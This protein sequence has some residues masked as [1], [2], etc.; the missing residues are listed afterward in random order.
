M[1]MKTLT[2][3][4]TVDVDIIQTGLQEK[5]GRNFSVPTENQKNLILSSHHPTQDQA[6]FLSSS[7]L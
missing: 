2:F 7:L 5:Q 6:F 1:A 4:C 3:S